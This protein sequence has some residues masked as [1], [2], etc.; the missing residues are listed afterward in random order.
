MRRAQMRCPSKISNLKRLFYLRMFSEA[1]QTGYFMNFTRPQPLATGWYY[2]C[3]SSFG[4]KFSSVLSI[5]FILLILLEII[6]LVIIYRLSSHRALSK[7]FTQFSQ[8]ITRNRPRT[9]T[10]DVEVV[11]RNLNSYFYENK[12]WNTNLFF[13]CCGVPRSVQ[14]NSFQPF[15]LK[16]HEATNVKAF[17][18]PIL[19][20]KRPC[21][22]ILQNLTNSGSCLIKV[23]NHYALST[24]KMS[25]SPRKLT[26]LSLAG[27]SKG[28]S[29]SRF[30]LHLFF[31]SFLCGIQDMSL[32][33]RILYLV[34]CC[35]FSHD[36]DCIPKCKLFF[37]EHGRKNAVFVNYYK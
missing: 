15:S 13:R 11:A 33:P 37:C 5:R 27:F 9:A 30:C 17:E 24:W 32:L 25:S 28:S 36:S 31:W 6:S 23:R 16:R 19:T 20:S 8:G 1:T 7:L 18:D 26:G 3:Q 22:S 4:V 12:V 35:V 34:S 14:N 21:K 29:V 2:G 10:H